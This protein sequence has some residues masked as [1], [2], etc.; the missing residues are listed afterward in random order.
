MNRP[1]IAAIVVVRARTGPTQD[2]SAWAEK[3]RCMTPIDSALVA[4]PQAENGSRSALAPAL[5][6]AIV[7]ALVYAVFGRVLEGE[8]VYDDLRLIG[9]NP[10]IIGTVG[11]WESLTTSHWGF[12]DPAAEG[13]I[14]YWRPLT[15][16][17]LRLAYWVGGGEPFAFHL[18]SLVL[19]FGA[20]LAAWSFFTRLFSNGRLGFCA[21]LLFGLH[22]VHVESVAWISALNDPLAG[23]L[24][25]LSLGAFL[26]WRERGSRG[27]ALVPAA[28]L[29]LGA[30]AKEQALAAIPMLLVLDVLRPRRAG[31]PT[32]GTRLK[33]WG[34]VLAGLLLYWMARVFVFGDLLAGL[35]RVASHFQM[36]LARALSFR[37]ELFG[38]FLGLLALPLRLEVFRPFRPELPPLDP[39][40]YLGLLASVLFV[41]ASLQAWR[42]RAD[43]LLAL[44]LLIPASLAPVLASVAAAGLFPFSD[45]YLYVGAAAAMGILV[46]LVEKL[47]RTIATVAVGVVATLFAVRVVTRSQV[48]HDE[49]TLFRAAAEE[50]PKSPYVHW[51][52]G[53]VLL[54]QYQTSMRRELLDEALLHFLSSLALGSDYGERAPK[55]GADAPLPERVAELERVVHETPRE[56]IRGDPTVWVSLDDRL[57]ANLGQGW[58]YLGMAD[59]DPEPNY[60]VPLLIFEQQTLHF[61]QSYEAWTALGSVYVTRATALVRSGRQEDVGAEIHEALKA[62]GKALALNP[63]FPEAW[64][65]QARAFVVKEDWDSARASFEKALQFEP[66]HHEYVMEIARTAIEGGRYDIAEQ[67]LARARASDPEDLQPVY[68]SGVLAAARSEWSEALARFEQVI[69]RQKDHGLAHLQEGKVLLRL[70]R[71]TEAIRELASACELLPTSFEAHYNLA[72]ILQGAGQP[73]SARQ[74]LDRAY[75]LAPRGQYRDDVAVRLAPSV[76]GDLPHARALAQL[77][78]GREDWN[79]VLLWLHLVLIEEPEW[80]EGHYQRGQALV[81][82]ARLDEARSSF[83]HALELA[84]DHFWSHHDLG[85][86]LQEPEPAA[87]L[88]HLRR[89]RELLEVPSIIDTIQPT[90]RQ[91]VKERLAQL[92][93]S[94]EQALASKDPH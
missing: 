76:E 39:A 62:F 58:C 13:A 75:Q 33:A 17:V 38:G 6:L 5:L 55:L 37:L 68:L 81:R 22:P 50:S 60:D 72:C 44:L 8:F 71:T 93:S 56:Q 34:P 21:G 41:V 54:V 90:F 31:E 26:R 20:T 46:L 61:P 25:L 80:A 42:K 53:R 89:A 7:L 1:P 63:A 16:L 9:R 29:L 87:A 4:E 86:M 48:W 15:V 36:T 47:P 2:P 35:D 66:G 70:S 30:L 27:P 24:V 3:I 23:M 91:V 94:C 79:A 83:E 77:S 82:L 43:R 18:F 74:Y 52:L 69:A 28:W 19:H 51:G 45:R 32:G 49:E 85:V 88:M 14:G 59:L 78:R 12:D 11:I 67:F 57:Q 84:P 65:N 92:I 73:E 64:A 40:F 10:R